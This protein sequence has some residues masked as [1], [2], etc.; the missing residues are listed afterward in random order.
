[1]TCRNG[2]YR[3]RSETLVFAFD[4]ANQPFVKR[5]E[6]PEIANQSGQFLL[7]HSWFT[8]KLPG[9]TQPHRLNSNANKVMDQALCIR[10]DY[11]AKPA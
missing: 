1:M 7:C 4:R 3:G 6:L 2:V 8:C 5:A 11:R 9:V 10:L